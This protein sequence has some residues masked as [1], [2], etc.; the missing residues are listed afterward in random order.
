MSPIVR[1][2]Y[3]VPRGQ[4]ETF[5][6]P[7]P[8][9]LAALVDRNRRLIGSW[10]FD[11]AGRPLGEFRAAARKEI[12]GLAARYA[13]RWNF[14]VDREWSEPA[15]VIA[16]GH[17][18][19]PFHPG[20]WFKNFLAG[21]LAGAVAL[22]PTQ[23]DPEHGRGVGGVALNLTV[24][25]DEARAGV[26]R[27][28][29]I[30]PG[31]EVVRSEVNFSS[32]IGGAAF[33][34][35]PPGAIRRE[36]AGEVLS[37]LPQ[38]AVQSFRR[39]WDRVVEAARDASSL[40]EAWTVARR[41]LEEELGLRNLE[42]PVSAMADSEA[43]R[44]FVAEMIQRREELF[45]AH[46]GALAEYRRVYRERS[47]AQPVPDLGRDGPRVELPFWVWRAG[48]SR[49]RLWVETA[50]EGAVV[51]LADRERI[52]EIDLRARRGPV[53][54]SLSG[55]GGSGGVSSAAKQVA[56]LRQA[57]WKIR[58]R[59]LTLTLFVRLAVGETFIHG[60]GGALYEKITDGIFERFF[61]VRPP[62]VVLASSTV[63]LPVESLWVE[64]PL[65][66]F[67]ATPRDLESA[68][69]AVR[70]WRHNPDRML[71]DAPRMRA[72]VRA[73]IAEKRCLV[74]G[75]RALDRKD[76]P[77][78]Y[79][80]IHAINETLARFE[81]DGP[82]AARKELARVERELKANA[83]LRGREYPFC[84]YPPEDLAAFYRERTA[85]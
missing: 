7:P 8:A 62:E 14:A 70:Q 34:E 45:A 77:A 28:P 29:R 55:E 53:R 65:E 39:C 1:E 59:A 63:H 73:L 40:A 35:Q 30:A 60:L 11:V 13:A 68:Q 31:G 67:P 49:R 64:R 9:D 61:R 36:A 32:G 51:L 80:R 17:Q 37:I 46:N 27:F 26:F 52:G 71:S 6:R 3:R 85:R 20:I 54:R 38:G 43:F 69:R 66:A 33:E 23:G 72:E 81:P 21:S 41:R 84:F 58:P 56:E 22:R 44:L 10:T 42:L 24:D 5:I 47:A 79:R 2:Y 50:G 12:L 19:P 82:E 18:P 83:I 78:A 57:G 16:T 75:M 25:S 4:R 48:Q 15:P 74:E 76:R